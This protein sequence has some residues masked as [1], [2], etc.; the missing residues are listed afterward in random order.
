M[1]LRQLRARLDRLERSLGPAAKQDEYGFVID[2]VLAKSLRDDYERS[3]LEKDATDR[4]MLRSTI[5]ER[6]MTIN[7][8]ADYGDGHW[9]DDCDRLSS[10]RVRR[11][12]GDGVLSVAEDA[13]EAHLRARVLAFEARQPQ[14]AVRESLRGIL[15]R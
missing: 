15:K 8:P 12:G 11:Q 9:R 2:P 6:A 5:T 13:E 7:C 14:P 3:Q 1:S 10:L 4:V